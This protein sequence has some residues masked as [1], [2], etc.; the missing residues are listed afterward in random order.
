MN[1][2]GSRE[3]DAGRVLMVGLTGPELSS[4][5]KRSLE[6]VRPGG[7]ILFRRNL[8]S[9]ERLAR[10]MLD[11]DGV[12]VDSPWIAVD[13]EGG[14]VSRLEPW[15][16]PTPSAS[17]LGS[18]GPDE[19]HRFG[20]ETGREL[21]R[22]GFNLDFA[23]VVDLCPPDRPNG[24]GDRSWGTDPEAVAELTGRFLDGLHT[25]G[26]A[27]CLKH[28]PGLGDTVVDSHVEMPV[29]RRDKDA[30]LRVDMLPYRELG[31]S[32]PVV[33]VCPVPGR[34]ASLSPPIITGLL[35]ELVRYTGMVTADDMEMGAV[36]HLDTD[37]AAAVQAIRAGTDLL[38]Y[39]ADLDRALAARDALVRETERDRAFAGRLEQAA[40]TVRST[41]ERWPRR[42]P[43]R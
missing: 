25:A 5:E 18:A 9:R 34:P 43:V 17:V 1:S 33:M 7:V 8:D 15:I 10:V 24:I 19:A 39:C 31:R 35:R 37:G 16:G 22:F 26:V 36:A 42:Y 38:P 29:C 13:Q 27:G 28:F 20:R 12:L 11:L 6:Q 23:P 21:A 32:A 4:G 41:A 2:H 14:R 3:A 30:L 40:K